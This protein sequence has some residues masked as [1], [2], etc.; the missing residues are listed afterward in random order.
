MLLSGTRERHLPNTPAVN[1]LLY[2]TGRDPKK[3]K[4]VKVYEITLPG[5]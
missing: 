1:T 3:V 2:F 5:G 4:K